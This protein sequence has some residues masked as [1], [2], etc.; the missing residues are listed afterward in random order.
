[1]TKKSVVSNKKTVNKLVFLCPIIILL[2]GAI[3]YYVFMPSEYSKKII[4]LDWLLS[5]SQDII[6]KIYYINNSL[7]KSNHVIEM[8]IF[9]RIW[10]VSLW[11]SLFFLCKY[12]QKKCDSNS[13]DAILVNKEP[14]LLI[15]GM[16]IRLK[17][18]DCH[19]ELDAL[20]YAIKCL[21][22]K[23]SLESDFGYGD[24]NVISCENNIAQQLQLLKNATKSIENGNI[25]ENI[26]T[27]N[28]IVLEI[29][30][31]LQKRTEMKKH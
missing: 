14:Y 28:N 16:S 25:A 15:Q 27:I 29:N 17:Q 18:V 24:N 3:V 19:V 13:T 4:F 22:E 10:F 21:E 31:L 30:I 9:W 26:K 5:D 2:I 20:I 23:L 7:S 8:Q 12:K 11:A 6:D 1:M